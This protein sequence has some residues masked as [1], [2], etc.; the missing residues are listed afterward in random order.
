MQEEEVEKEKEELQKMWDKGR[1]RVKERNK[2][3]ELID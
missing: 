1:E 2:R 3:E